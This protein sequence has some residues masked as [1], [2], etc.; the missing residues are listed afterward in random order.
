MSSGKFKRR[1]GHGA[2]VHAQSTKRLI[3]AGTLTLLAVG[4]GLRSF[5]PEKPGAPT[6]RAHKIITALRALPSSPLQP[7]VEAEPPSADIPGR[8][9]LRSPTQAA[10]RVT[11]PAYSTEPLHVE[12]AKTGLSVDVQMRDVFKVV[13]Q[14]ADGYFVY[15]HAHA[16]GGTLLH[17]EIE[18]GAEDY[19][20][21]ETKPAKPEVAYDVD[22]K[23]VHA[24][25]LVEGVVEFLDDSGTP[26]LRAT[27]PFIVGADGE[28]TDAAVAIENCTVDTDP[29]PPWGRDVTAPGTDSCRLRVRWD[30]ERVKYPAVLDPRWVSTSNMTSARQDFTGTMMSTGKVLAV[31]GRTS[32]TSTTGLATAEVFDPATRTWATTASLA[33]GRYLQMAVQPTIRPTR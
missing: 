31:G 13:A 2:A 25:R 6:R 3:V 10:V 22:V 24:V 17:R 21:F 4:T 32:G 19:V 29:A 11:L 8:D 5:W 7:Q 28:R 9:I 33:G 23:R 26:R 16:T 1:L 27:P 12:D 14:S 18:D 15:P 20:S 30:D